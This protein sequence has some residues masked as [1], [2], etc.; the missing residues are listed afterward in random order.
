MTEYRLVAEPQ[1]DLDVAAV[2][3]WYESEQDDYGRLALIQSAM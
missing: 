1:A 3:F 2:F